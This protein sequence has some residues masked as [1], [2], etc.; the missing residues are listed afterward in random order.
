MAVLGVLKA[1][2]AYVPLDP[3]YPEERLAMMLDDSRARVLLTESRLLEGRLT[4][5]RARAV[6]LDAERTEIAREPPDDPAVGVLSDNLIYTI[7]TS[8]STGRPKGAGVTHG[9]FVNLV[10]WFVSE[11]GLTARERVLI[12]S[13]FSFDLTQKDIFA[14]LV[15]GG[16]LHLLSR[17][18]FDD[19]SDISETIAGHEYTSCRTARRAPSTRSW[20]ARGRTL[21]DA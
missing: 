11:F 16:Q 14:P 18:A 4:D 17:S 12:V 15:S 6:C 7:Y 2:G 1:G 20:K 19:A 21:C 3:A 5:A 8:G 13:S 9:G 10:N